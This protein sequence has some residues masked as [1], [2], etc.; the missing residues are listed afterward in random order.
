MITANIVSI[1]ERIESLKQCI[2]SLY[3]QVDAINVFLNNYKEVPDFLNS[4]KIKNIVKSNNTLGDAGKFYFVNQ[5]EGYYLSCDD[6]IIY[7]SGYVDDIIDKI[8]HYECL[9]SYHGRK[10]DLC[11]SCR[12]QISS[13]YKG[14]KQFYHCQKE[15]KKDKKVDV[16]GSGVA[17][18]HTSFLRPPLDFFKEPNMADIWL[19]AYAKQQGVKRICLAH[20]EEWIKSQSNKGIYMTNDA[21]QTYWFNQLWKD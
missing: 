1:P 5:T 8:N 6:D 17:G 10:F 14:Y 19:S 15:V 12:K 9:V 11:N 13:Y 21:L 7:P 20:S 3:H 16:I 18:F 2:N 4:S